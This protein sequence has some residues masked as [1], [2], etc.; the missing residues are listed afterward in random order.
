MK[1]DEIRA[2]QEAAGIPDSKP[3]IEPQENAITR[4]E[5]LHI[6]GV[7]IKDLKLEAPVLAALDYYATDEGMAEKNATRAEPSGVTVG[8]EPWDKS[9]Q[10]KRD[11]VKER[12][13]NTYEAR[14]PLREVAEE[15]AQPGMRARYMSQ[16]KL[17]DGGNRDYKVVK[18]PNGD[19]VMVR[20]M[21]LGHIPEEVAVAR[22]KYYQRRGNDL[23]KQLNEKYLNE[24]GPTAKSDQ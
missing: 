23:L 19:P 17:K 16:K 20:G 5:E 14:D 21:V 24:G 18:Q 12:G 1:G 3:F 4:M 13:Y 8:A 22:N 11:D 2:N 15:Y 10:Q 6:N 9:L 7:L